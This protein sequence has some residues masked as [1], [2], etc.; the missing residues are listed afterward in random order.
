MN[1]NLPIATGMFALSVAAMVLFFV[2][3]CLTGLVALV[4][5][6]RSGCGRYHDA[7]ERERNVRGLTL[8]KNWLTPAQ[9]QSYEKFGYF[10]V[11]GS[12]SGIHYRIHHGQQA[13]VEQLD[14][15]GQP[16]CAWCFVPV[17]DLVA[18][19]VMLAQKIALENDERA[20]MSIA[21]KFAALRVRRRTSARPPPL[22][23]SQVGAA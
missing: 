8:L 12:D 17:G 14:H 4:V 20:A 18:G 2:V 19:D 16:V 9:L 22:P 21:V 11:I 7:Y 1:L 6:R 15:V 23:A 10:D 3:W 5:F 13:N